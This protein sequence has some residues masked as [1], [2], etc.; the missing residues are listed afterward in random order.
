[1]QVRIISMPPIRCGSPSLAEV[2]RL[3]LLAK[4]STSNRVIFE[5]DDTGRSL[6]VWPWCVDISLGPR[7]KI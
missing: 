4:I 6:R 7:A 3:D 2:L 1:M 5:L